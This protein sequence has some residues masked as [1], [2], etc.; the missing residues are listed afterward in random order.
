MKSHYQNQADALFNPPEAQQL[1]TS[2]NANVEA[3]NIELIIL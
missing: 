1:L 2:N 3:F